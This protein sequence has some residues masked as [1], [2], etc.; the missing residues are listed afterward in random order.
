MK[1]RIILGFLGGLAMPGLAFAQSYPPKI[2]VRDA[3]A[4][5]PA[6]GLTSTRAYGEIINRAGEPDVLLGATSAWAAR[7]VIEHYVMDGYNMKAVAVGS[8]KV[9]ARDTLKLGP[10]DYHLRLIDLSQDLKP[11]YKIPITLRFANGGLVEMEASVSNQLLGN[12]DDR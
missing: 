10:G 11:D 5:L 4:R 8:V 2:E 12:M 1:R 7:V 6:A 9:G 3:W